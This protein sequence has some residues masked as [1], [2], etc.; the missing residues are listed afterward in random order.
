MILKY[1]NCSISQDQLAKWAGTTRSGTGHDGLRKAVQN[2]GTACKMKFQF[3]EYKFT[4]LQNVKNNFIAKNIPVITHVKT[5]PLGR[6]KSDV[7][8]YMVARGY[9]DDAL[10]IND[11]GRDV[12]WVPNANMEK[13]LRAVTWAPQVIAITRV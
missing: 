10:Y 6:Y 11:P 1:Y 3:A 12:W 5:G 9:R 13:A 4:A 7:G 2:A 8:H